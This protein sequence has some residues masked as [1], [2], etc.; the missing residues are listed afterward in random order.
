MTSPVGTLA[1]MVE[2]SA[3][4]LEDAKIAFIKAAILDTSAKLVEGLVEG[5]L[6]QLVNIRFVECELTHLG[7]VQALSSVPSTPL[8]T[9]PNLQQPSYTEVVS[10]EKITLSTS[11]GLDN[12]WRSCQLILMR[13]LKA[14]RSLAFVK[15][16]RK[17][18]PDPGRFFNLI[19]RLRL[20]RRGNR[21]GR[22]Q[23]L[24]WRRPKLKAVTVT[25][26]VAD[27]DVHMTNNNSV[28]EDKVVAEHL[29]A[30]HSTTGAISPEVLFDKAE[31]DVG[32]AR[33]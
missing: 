2:P 22:Q 27:N 25:N 13:L 28:V 23:R 17:P 30:G 8:S 11:T 33:A 9:S 31:D 5:H 24:Q 12:K 3:T 29:H 19:L 7:S 21:S 15:T 14:R 4:L 1:T 20:R 10:M 16:N 32:W 18:L 6:Y 26:V